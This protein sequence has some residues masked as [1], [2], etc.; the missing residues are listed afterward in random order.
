MLAPAAGAS[1]TSERDPAPAAGGRLAA[2]DL[3]VEL[4]PEAGGRI[5]AFRTRGGQDGRRDILV[6]M[7]GPV[8]DPLR[9]PKAGCYPLAPFSNRIRGASFRFEG[10]RIGLPA[11]PSCR[12]H[13]LHGFAQLRPWTLRRTGEA[14]A[15]MTYGHQPDD[16]PWAFEAEQRLRLDDRGLT[17]ELAVKNQS[18]EPMPLGLGLHPYLAIRPGDRIRFDAT[19]EWMQDEAGCGVALRRLDAGET[20]FDAAHGPDATTRYFA[21]WSG[22]ALIRGGDGWTVRVLADA[23]LDHFVFHVPQ[24]GAYA[25]MEPVS[26][27]ADAFNL[28]DAGREETGF[29]T[30]EP[31]CEI[32]ARARIEAA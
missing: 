28:A 1:E 20:R 29:R 26:H 32:V 17:I 30:L 5:A 16:W 23:P 31:G 10:R 7:D 19:S 13:A 21:G 9:W 27:V 3:S 24:G 12:P 18:P 2:G 14:Q 11:H 6:P 4:R 22:E 15:V 25:C 8:A